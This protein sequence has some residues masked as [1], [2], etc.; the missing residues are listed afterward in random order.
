FVFPNPSN[1]FESIF[2]ELLN[3]NNLTTSVPNANFTGIKV[4][5]VNGSALPNQLLEGGDRA[6][7]G[8]F[9]FHL[10]DLYLE[11]GV[12]VT[13]DFVAPAD[14]IEGFQFT[15]EFDKKALE[16]TN[17]FSSTLTESNFG[18]SMLDNGIITTS[19]NKTISAVPAP[20]MSYFTITFIPHENVRLRDVLHLNSKFTKAEAYT[21]DLQFQNVALSFGNDVYPSEYGL[22]QNTPNPFRRLTAIGF[23]LPDAADA[24]LAILD[25]SGRVVK[26]IH[27]EYAEGYNEITINREELPAAQGVFYYRLET[28]N[29]TATRKMILSDY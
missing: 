3:F 25:I 29:F 10:G 9:T 2:P 11:K 6:T 12:P 13:V 28:K 5:D 4:G 21:K 1:P 23:N 20:E 27:G 22:F 26:F 8:I 19:W 14:D 18:L 15:L 7:H 17:L 16:F 24:S